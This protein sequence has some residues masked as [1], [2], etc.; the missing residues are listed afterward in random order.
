MNM[1][2]AAVDVVA[3]N[4]APSCLL[5]PAPSMLMPTPPPPMQMILSRVL[6]KVFPI[7]LI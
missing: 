5:L 7:F 6:M 4:A 3:A 1:D 2:P